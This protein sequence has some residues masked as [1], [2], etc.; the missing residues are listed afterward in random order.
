[1][2]LDNSC[3]NHWKKVWSFKVPPKISIF[4]WKYF[5][6]ILPLKKLLNERITCGIEVVCSL[7]GVGEESKD[8]LFWRCPIVHNTWKL[9]LDWWSIKKSVLNGQGQFFDMI[10]LINGNEL[11]V[12]W[13][14]ALIAML[15]T[16]WLV[17][18]DKIYKKSKCE[19]EK[20]VWLVKIRSYKWLLAV[21]KMNLGLESL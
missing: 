3:I 13:S 21:G 7:C 2:G 15:W 4:F 11:R 16:I 9:F 17:R 1:M 18:N 20:L 12:A 19:E 8:H 14:T 10:R 5:H 6:D